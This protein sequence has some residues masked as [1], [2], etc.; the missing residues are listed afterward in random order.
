M[1]GIL[2]KWLPTNSHFSSLHVLGVPS[3]RAGAG[4]VFHRKLSL[5]LKNDILSL[6][7]LVNCTNIGIKSFAGCYGWN[8]SKIQQCRG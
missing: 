4:T 3:V 2:T 7:F 1:E 6:M 5:K 8:G